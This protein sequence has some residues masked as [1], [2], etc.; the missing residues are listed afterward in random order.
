MRMGLALE[1]GTSEH[2]DRGEAKRSSDRR[3]ALTLL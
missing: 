3:R 1:G 2:A